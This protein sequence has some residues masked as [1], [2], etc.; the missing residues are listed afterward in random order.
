M[1]KKKIAMNYKK[2]A[3]KLKFSCFFKGDKVVYLSSDFLPSHAF[4]DLVFKAM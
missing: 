4:N 3:A 2:K 1:G